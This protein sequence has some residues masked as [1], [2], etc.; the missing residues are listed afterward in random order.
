MSG[1]SLAQVVKASFSES[2]GDI[3]FG[4][5]VDA[6]LQGVGLNEQDRVSA[7]PR[8]RALTSC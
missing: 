2:V 3:V 5:E 7:G 8:S 4:K 6:R 1:T